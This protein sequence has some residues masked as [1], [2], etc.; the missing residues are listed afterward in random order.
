MRTTQCVRAGWLIGALGACMLVAGAAR[1]D[2][3]TERP[4]SILIF[5][6][7]VAN[8]TRD[9]V[10]Q[11]TNTGNVAD[12]ARCFYINGAK[13][14][15]GVAQCNETDFLIS[16]TK[17]Q[18]TS[19]VVSAGRNP[20]GIGGLG[21]GLVP[22]V[23]AGFTG[24]LVCAEVDASLAPVAMNQLKG[25]AT[26]KGSAGNPIDLSKYSGI[27]LIGNTSGNNGDNDLSLDDSEYN[28]CPAASRV[29]FVAP[30]AAD[31]IVFGLGNAGLCINDSSSACTT[32]TDCTTA[33][34]YCARYMCAGGTNNGGACAS[35]SDC[36]GGSCG[37]PLAS[38]TTTVTVLPCNLDLNAQIPTTTTVQVKA[39]DA[40]E[41]LFTT[42]FPVTCWGSFDISA[43]P[44]PG[45]AVNSVGTEL[46]TLELYGGG[47]G[48]FLAVV[49]TLHSDSIFNSASAATNTHVEPQVCVGS[50]APTVNGRPCT[51]NSDCSSGGTCPLPT[52]VIRL[53]GA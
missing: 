53:P 16:L 17:Q 29:N 30:G 20:T 21:P 27:A 1:A 42:S 3:T 23:P 37:P 49:E 9:T 46:G 51:N 33:G 24:A 14:R 2:V 52:A 31:P 44:G 39:W 13:G 11:I 4:G 15:T 40:T 19:W 7:V 6:K 50:G 48:P 35:N 45:P 47:G 25:D 8:G 10:I 28:A 38:V 12:Q 41:Q 18:P 36:P 34:S 5:P 32:N 22:P 43:S 26:L